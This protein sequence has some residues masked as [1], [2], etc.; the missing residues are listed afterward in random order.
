MGTIG[1]LRARLEAFKE[2]ERARREA[3]GRI[4]RELYRAAGEARLWILASLGACH[5]KRHG[6]WCEARLGSLKLGLDTYNG[7]LH[8]WLD[9]RLAVYGSDEKTFQMYVTEDTE[10]AERALEAIRSIPREVAELAEIAREARLEGAHDVYRE[11]V[12]ELERRGV[13][14]GRE[15]A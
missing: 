5:D 7:Y 6:Y 14:L 12:K 8:V 11:A 2:A 9:G 1:E 15:E 10:L 3:L 13:S 4:A